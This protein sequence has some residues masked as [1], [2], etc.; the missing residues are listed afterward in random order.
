M[1]ANGPKTDNQF[2]GDL[3]VGLSGGYKAQ[4]FYLSLLGEKHPHLLH[5][6]NLIYRR[7]G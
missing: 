2:L 5:N 3:A 1:V 7:F 4:H 6:Q